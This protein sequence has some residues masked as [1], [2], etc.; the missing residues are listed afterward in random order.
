MP[1][2]RNSSV[3][4]KPSWAPVVRSAP[5]LPQRTIHCQRI[6]ARKT[7]HRGSSWLRHSV[8]TVAPG[9]AF[10]VTIT[11]AMNTTSL[12]SCLH[13]LQSLASGGDGNGTT[14]NEG[15]GGDG[16]GG[17]PSGQELFQIAVT[18]DEDESGDAD[19]ADE[20]EEEIGEEEEEESEEGEIEEFLDEDIDEDD[21]VD[22]TAPFECNKISAVGLPNGPGVPRDV[23]LFAGINCQPGF[24][25]T[26]E[27]LRKDL[28]TLSQFVS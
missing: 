15:G 14:P 13:Y 7:D 1:F 9:F 12:K 18:E 26:Q 27:E 11:G 20:E 17:N 3:T 21:Y 25:C 24:R 8:A 5:P 19:E 23:D 22:P 28:K 6:C 2:V 16:G 10:A 4:R